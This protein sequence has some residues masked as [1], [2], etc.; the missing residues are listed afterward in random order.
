MN[1][2]RTAAST[3]GIAAIFF[4]ATAS[5]GDDHH[6]GNRSYEVTVTNLTKGQII[7][8]PVLVTHTRKISLFM[9]GAPASDELAEVAENGNGAPLVAALQAS[10]YVGDA[11]SAAGGLPP[12]ASATYVLKSSRRFNVLSVTGM[13]VNTNDAIAVVN[14]KSLP[15]RRNSSSTFDALAYDAGSEANNESCAFIPGPACPPDSG[16]ARDVAGAENFVH[17]HNGVHGIADLNEAAYDWRNPVAR[18]HVK[19][20]R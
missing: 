11:Q 17:I 9:A 13:L 10:S 7:S 2:F 16:N 15:R 19:R 4:G 8:P 20:I 14:S 3:L 18:I 6:Y 1:H 5:A 12:G